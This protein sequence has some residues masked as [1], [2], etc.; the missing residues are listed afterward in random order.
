[1]KCAFVFGSILGVAIIIS[2]VTFVRTYIKTRGK[3]AFSSLW[4]YLINP[5]WYPMPEGVPEET[6]L[7]IRKCLSTNFFCS[8]WLLILAVL[9]TGLA[10]TFGMCR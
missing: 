2:V 8:V 7:E 9:G 10:K 3:I 6:R 1:M 4:L 5:F